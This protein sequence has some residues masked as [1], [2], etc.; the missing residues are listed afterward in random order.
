MA[1]VDLETRSRVKILCELGDSAKCGMAVYCKAEKT[2]IY[3]KERHPRGE[4]MIDNPSVVRLCTG[5]PQ[6]CPSRR[7]FM[8]TMR[9]Q[10]DEAARA[11]RALEVEKDQDSE[12]LEEFVKDIKE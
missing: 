11:V 5:E 3:G 9:T 1:H 6:R 7:S 4:G 8:E 2:I 10:Q 12:L